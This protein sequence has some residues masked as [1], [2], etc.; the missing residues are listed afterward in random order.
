LLLLILANAGGSAESA[1]PGYVD[2][3]NVGRTNWQVKRF[4]ASPTRYLTVEEDGQ[5]TLMAR[6]QNSA[7]AL[8]LPIEVPVADSLKLS[9]RWRVTRGL[10]NNSRERQK[11]GDDFAARIFVSFDTDP[12]DKN[13]RAICYAWASEEAIDSVY[14]SPYSENVAMIIVQSGEEKTGQ[15]ITETRDIAQDYRRVFG[16][17]PST[18]CALAVMVDTDNTGARATAWFSAFTL[19]D[20]TPTSA[21]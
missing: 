4:N 21:R 6:S 9:W 1:A 19:G 3:G 20:V 16:E 7:S 14:P 12:F 10:S 8:W 5:K 18:L 11:A 2:L 13:S 17:E 15:W